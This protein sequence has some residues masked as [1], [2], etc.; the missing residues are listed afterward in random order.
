LPLL[1]I[2]NL[3]IGPALPDWNPVLAYSMY[4]LWL[5]LIIIPFSFLSYIWIEKPWMQLGT[6]LLSKGKDTSQDG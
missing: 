6:S 3:Y 5:W 4:W 1:L 2:Y